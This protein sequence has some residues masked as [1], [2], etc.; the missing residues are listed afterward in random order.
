[1]DAF[2]AVLQS[3]FSE[4]GVDQDGQPPVPSTPPDLRSYDHILSVVVADL[5]K[6]E[7]LVQDLRKP[8]SFWEL[9]QEVQSNW[10]LGA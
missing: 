10:G 6:F 9:D 2:H 5:G 4:V 8:H 7:L 1:M 3:T